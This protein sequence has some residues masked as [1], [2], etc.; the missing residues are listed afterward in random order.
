MRRRFDVQPRVG[1]ETR[2]TAGPETGATLFIVCEAA[3]EVGSF[4]KGRWVGFWGAALILRCFRAAESY[5][6][7]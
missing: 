4:V 6:E 1:L 3:Q 2:T 5:G 7:K